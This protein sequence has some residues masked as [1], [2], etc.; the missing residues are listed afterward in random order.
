M[1]EAGADGSK[2]SE[3]VFG[4][5]SREAME[6]THM[7]LGTIQTYNEGQIGTMT[8]T[9]GDFKK[10]GASDEDTENL[11]NIVRNLNTVKIA[12]F[13]KEMPDKRVKLS[14]RSKNGLNVANV[15]KLFDGGGHA[16]AAGA[17]LPGPLDKAFR[18]VL[19]ACQAALK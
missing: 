1:L 2:V 13:L 9:L 11:I 15:A 19:Q 5:I 14:L 8:L 10:S 18:E 4:D 17:V 6:L 16:Y 3:T 7:A 12:I